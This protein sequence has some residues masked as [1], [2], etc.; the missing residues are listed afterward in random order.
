MKVMKEHYPNVDTSGE[1]A[2]TRD[3]LESKGIV[4]GKKISGRKHKSAGSLKQLFVKKGILLDMID[5]IK[6]ENFEGYVATSF[7]W[8][9]ATR[10]SATLNLQIQ[11]ITKEE[12]FITAIT[13]DKGRRA[14]HTEGKRGEKNI[15]RTVVAIATISELKIPFLRSSVAAIPPL[16]RKLSPVTRTFS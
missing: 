8:E 7:M 5:W 4:V 9:T 11:N 1:R 14:I 6:K 15:T 3:F 12:E 13:Y 2:V 16:P 10:V